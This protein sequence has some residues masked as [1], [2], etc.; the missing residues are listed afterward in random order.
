MTKMEKLKFYEELVEAISEPLPKKIFVLAAVSKTTYY[1][2]FKCAYRNRSVLEAT[3]R[4][5]E[6]KAKEFTEMAAKCQE[7]LNEN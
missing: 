2:V 7:I 5:L 3:K 1:N 4:I 6:A